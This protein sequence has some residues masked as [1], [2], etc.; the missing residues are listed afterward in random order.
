MGRRKVITMAVIQTHHIE[1]ADIGDPDS[2]DWTVDIKASWH[3]IIT[4][5]QRKK[6]TPGQYAILTGFVHALLYEW[7]RMRREL[8]Q[9]EG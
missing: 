4:Q 6:T 7:H 3:K 1:Y 5:I 2:Q 8:D 9:D